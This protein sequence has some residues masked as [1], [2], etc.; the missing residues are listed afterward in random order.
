MVDPISGAKRPTAR[1]GCPAA[2]PR[3]AERALAL[4]SEAGA[5]GVTG[6]KGEIVVVGPRNGVSVRVGG[7]RVVVLAMLLAAALVLWEAAG[8]SGRRRLRV[9]AA[10]QA[11]AAR[12]GAPAGVDPFL[13]QHKPL[14]RGQAGDAQV[15]VDEAESPLAWLARRKGRDG[16]PF[17]DAACL[18]A[19][20][21]L[22]RDLTIGAMLPCTTANWSAAV[23]SGS[24]SH[25]PTDFTDAM[26]AA[27]QRARAALGA[28]GPDLSGL[29][30]DIC[31]FLKGLETIERER[32]WPARSGKL[33]LE[34]ALRQLCRHYGFE[35]VARGRATTG[36]RHWG[37][38]DF[39]PVLH[40]ALHMGA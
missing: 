26:I 14:A 9:T 11:H 19:G 34:L 15:L 12:H 23:A 28:V 2:L 6:E 29:L 13:A 31:G 22:R 32:G 4:L 18:E 24:R 39:R 37:V 1:R 36:L 35:A 17:V 27:R 7:F 33:V 30:I 38:G 3:E 40:G 16:L 25:G 10:G 21:R 20:E 5:Y 8:P